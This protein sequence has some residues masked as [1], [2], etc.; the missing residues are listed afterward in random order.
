MH[1]PRDEEELGYLWQLA[2]EMDGT[3]IASRRFQEFMQRVFR[4]AGYNRL[5]ITH[6]AF[7]NP[8]EDSL[9]ALHGDDI[10]AEAEPAALD[11][12]EV[13]LKA[14]TQIKILGR[15]GPNAGT[16]AR[17]LKRYIFYLPGEGYELL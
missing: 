2:D 17:Y 15:I 14:Q 5:A 13:V 6:Q 11:K 12:L 3:R 1:P 7:Y 8:E 9:A 16:L 4:D 10:I